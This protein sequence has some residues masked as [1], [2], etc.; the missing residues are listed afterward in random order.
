MQAPSSIGSALLWGYVIGKMPVYTPFLQF[1]KQLWKPKGHLIL[2]LHGN[3]FFTAKFNLE[4]DLIAVLEGGPWTMAHRP[5]IIKKWSPD[6]RMEQ[7]RLTSIPVWVRLPNLPIHLWDIECLGRIGSLIG[8]P[9]FMDSATERC[10]RG[11][12]ARICVKVEANKPLPDKV[13]VDVAPGRRES[14]KVDY[15]WKHVVNTAKPLAMTK[16][17]VARDPVDLR[18]LRS[19][20]SPNLA[21]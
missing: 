6:L 9:L 7:E 17:D 21:S 3:G 20:P 14:F 15:D 10:S 13:L 2:L 5:F 19:S 1:L 8:K 4:E 12:Y 16:N 18:I 11:T